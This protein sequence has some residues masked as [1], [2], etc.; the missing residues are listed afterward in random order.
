MLGKAGTGLPTLRLS[1]VGQC[2]AH[3]RLSLG[4]RLT[5]SGFREWK[6]QVEGKEA[7]ERDQGWRREGMHTCLG[8]GSL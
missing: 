2:R 3:A 1:C 7:D 8:G 5:V 4:V 6:R